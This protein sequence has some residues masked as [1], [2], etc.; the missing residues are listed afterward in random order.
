MVIFGNEHLKPTQNVI[1]QVLDEVDA[2]NGG[3]SNDPIEV[4]IHEVDDEIQLLYRRG[5]Q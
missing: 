4:V 1:H 3:L 2:E 5:W